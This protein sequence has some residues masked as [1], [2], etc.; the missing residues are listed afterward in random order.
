MTKPET[1]IKSRIK[2][3]PYDSLREYMDAIE[4]HGNVIRIDKI[5]QDN[6]ELTG[7]M[8]KLIDKHGWRELLH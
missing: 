3:G 7:L 5:D 6:Y 1:G 4:A 2:S 8:Y